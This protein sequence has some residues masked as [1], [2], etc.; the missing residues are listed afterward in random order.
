MFS[1]LGFVAAQWTI[2]TELGHRGVARSKSKLGCTKMA[3][4]AC[5]N[6]VVDDFT[7]NS[8]FAAECVKA[9]ITCVLFRVSFSRL[10]RILFRR[11]GS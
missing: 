9:L 1:V 7:A 4:R 5:T 2:L 6:F 3:A 8:P 11:P 10:G